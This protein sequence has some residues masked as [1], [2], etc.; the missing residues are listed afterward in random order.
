MHSLRILSQETNILRQTNNKRSKSLRSN[1]KL[2]SH[3][4]G[5]GY[6]AGGGGAPSFPGKPGYIWEQSFENKQQKK[7]ERE[8]K[9]SQVLEPV[10][11]EVEG[12]SH[13]LHQRPWSRHRR[14]ELQAF[15]ENW[16]SLLACITSHLNKSSQYTLSIRVNC[17]FSRQPKLSWLV[18]QVARVIYS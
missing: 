6:E 11:A 10:Q 7:R 18:I 14:A 15:P 13:Q 5:A 2:I 4:C 17:S 8:R 16:R 1:I 3:T 9:V 12:Q